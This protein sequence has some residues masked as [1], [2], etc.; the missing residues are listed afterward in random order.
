METMKSQS[1]NSNGNLELIIGPMFAG[2][3]TELFEKIKGLT[4]GLKS[5]LINHANDDRY[6]KN[7]ISTHNKEQLPC[8]S[9]KKLNEIFTNDTFNAEYKRCQYIFIDE[10]QFFEDLKDFVEQSVNKDKKK[11]Y[12]AALS[13]DFKREPFRPIAETMEKF[14]PNKTTHLTASCD[15]CDQVAIF[16]HLLKNNQSESNIQ[17]GGAD[18]YI[19]VCRN[20][21]NKL[22]GTV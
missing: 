10:G 6:G 3:T 12:I 9:I 18:K 7:V 20:C 17:I 16:S 21:Y 14:I 5:L 8:I 2:K 13:S 15:R 22:N 1:E 19:A 4:E 11:V